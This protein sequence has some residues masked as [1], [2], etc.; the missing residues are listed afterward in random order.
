MF[1]SP[2]FMQKLSA[3]VI[4]LGCF[5]IASWPAEVALP[6]QDSSG[7]TNFY[8]LQYQ[9]ICLKIISDSTLYQQGWDT[10]RQPRFWR[11]AMQLPPE[12]VL[13]NIAET[14]EI[15]D[16][17]TQF[18]S[19]F[20]SRRHK[21]AYEDSVKRAHGMSR[22]DEL[23]FT[24]GRSHFYRFAEVLPQIDQAVE[25]FTEE[26]VDPWYAQAIL[27]IESPARLQ[28]SVDGAYGAFQL[29][30][31]VARELG[32]VVNDTLDERQ[33]FEKSAR[34]AARFLK[35]VCL[36]HTRNLCEGYDL[37]VEEQE[38][39]FR[40]LTMHVYHAGIGN[41]RRV[42]HKI[43]PAEGGV[44]LITEM[45]QTKSR[46]FGNASQ[47]YSQII[48]AAMMEMDALVQ[49]QGIICPPDLAALQE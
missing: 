43:R 49:K 2:F 47:N 25:I 37:P 42:I 17:L 10:L 5:L 3:I 33:D 32:L 36:V 29:M 38:A 9:D 12:T 27:L 7:E 44:G 14:R 34:G 6:D 40:L 1:H 24:N 19:I 20:Y 21:R 18:H 26:G 11:Q 4:G 8:Q 35:R 22:R 13:V 15:V 16:T 30:A 23:F 39:W 45:W 28:Y 48:L 46:H 41:V 31:G